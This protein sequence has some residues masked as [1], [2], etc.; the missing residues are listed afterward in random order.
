MIAF[1]VSGEDGKELA[2]NFD[3]TPTQEVVGEEPVR[4]PVADVVSHLVN[5]GHNDERVTRFAQRYLQRLEDFV[6]KKYD[7][8]P[9]HEGNYDITYITGAD[10]RKGRE[11]LNDCL[12]RCMSTKSA[13]FQVDPLAIY[14]L[15]YSQMDGLCSG[16]D[17]FIERDWWPFGPKYL[18]GFKEEANRFGS[19]EFIEDDCIE[20][21]LALFKDKERAGPRAVAEMIKDLRHTMKTLAEYPIE[22]DTGQYRPKLQPRQHMDME[23]EIANSLSQRPDYQA[24]VRMRS[25]EYDIQTNQK[26][27]GLSGSGLIARINQIKARMRKERYCRSCLEV[28]K[29]IRERQERWKDGGA[30]GQK[31]GGPPPTYT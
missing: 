8:Y 24:K 17:P 18:R 23:N 3:T 12:Y 1:G 21:Y 28:E 4:A 13:S 15:A 20:G 27:S 16:L 7:Q 29:E 19:P 22:V 25:G 14:I 26:P 9:P 10:I 11:V 6:D 31:P 5:K 2:K 30:R